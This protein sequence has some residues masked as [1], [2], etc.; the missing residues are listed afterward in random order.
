M[1][2]Q[3]PDRALALAV[4]RSEHGH[5]ADAQLVVGVPFVGEAPTQPHDR[6]PELGREAGVRASGAFDRGNHVLS[7]THYLC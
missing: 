6:Q 7:L 1:L 2:G 4:E 3:L 5:L